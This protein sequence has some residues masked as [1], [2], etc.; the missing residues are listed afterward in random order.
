MDIL[1][2]KYNIFYKFQLIYEPVGLL[3]KSEIIMFHFEQTVIHN[4]RLNVQNERNCI[5]NE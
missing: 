3:K 4:Q 5:Q 1:Y 2:I